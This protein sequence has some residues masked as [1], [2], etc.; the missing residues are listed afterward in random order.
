[1]A[2]IGFNERELEKDVWHIVYDGSNDAA[3]TMISIEN[4]SSDECSFCIAFGQDSLSQDQDA[5]DD[6]DEFSSDDTYSFLWSDTLEPNES[7]Y[8]DS[9]Q[10]GKIL[11]KSGTQFA[12]ALN[13]DG[14][15]EVNISGMEL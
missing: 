4:R 12:I 15:L 6:N 14:E 10:G 8:F 3:F 13:G 2:V 5:I 1:M 7:M 9:S 11:T